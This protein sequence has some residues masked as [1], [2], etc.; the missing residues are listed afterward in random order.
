M[1]THL[2]LVSINK[3]CLMM[4]TIITNHFININLRLS[5]SLL[6]TYCL[7]DLT[8]IRKDFLWI[9]R[10]DHTWSKHENLKWKIKIEE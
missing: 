9:Y 3:I 7:H 6:F 1:K 2:N 10:E 8:I 4:V 5:S